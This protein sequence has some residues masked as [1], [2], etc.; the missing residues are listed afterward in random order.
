LSNLIT[1]AYIYYIGV[2]HTGGKYSYFCLFPFV[3]TKF[4]N[5][6]LINVS[7]IVIAGVW[8]LV[9]SLSCMPTLYICVLLF[10]IKK[11]IYE[12]VLQMKRKSTANRS[13][14]RKIILTFSCQIQFPLHK[15]SR[16]NLQVYVKFNFLSTNSI[17]CPKKLSYSLSWFKIMKML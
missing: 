16:M 17:L 9:I 13:R 14:E 2:A 5:N 15:F 4:S 11:N 7:L 12:K 10:K 8:M 6:S 3:S 1:K